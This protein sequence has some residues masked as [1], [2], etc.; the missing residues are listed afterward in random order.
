[1][2]RK[3]GY[4]ARLDER[5]G[6]TRGKQSGKKMSASGRRKVSK[7]TRKPKGTYGFAKNT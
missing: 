2:A 3:Q 7:A 5:L 1:M 4:N 6:I